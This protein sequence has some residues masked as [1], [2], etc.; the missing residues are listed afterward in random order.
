[1]NCRRNTIPA[2]QLPEDAAILMRQG[3]LSKSSLPSGE[4]FP[5]LANNLNLAQFG[6]ARSF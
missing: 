1:M 4:D 2:W 6:L 5:D 3:W